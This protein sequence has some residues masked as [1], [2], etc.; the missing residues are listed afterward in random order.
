LEIISGEWID[1]RCLKIYFHQNIMFLAVP[2][3]Q[4]IAMFGNSSLGPIFAIP[5]FFTSSYF[6]KTVQM[7]QFRL[8]G[9]RD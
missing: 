6:L 1:E 5:G 3:K 7:E 2:G 4:F 8:L 9:C